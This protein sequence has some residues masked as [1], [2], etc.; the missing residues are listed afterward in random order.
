MRA[1]IGL[2][3]L[4]TIAS[5]NTHAQ[6]V[7]PSA[8]SDST[9]LALKRRNIDSLST[10]EY[11]MF[12]DRDRACVAAMGKPDSAATVQA[13]SSTEDELYFAGLAEGRTGASR[14]G[15]GG[16]FAGSF[17]TGVALG[18][19]G[20]AIMY[21]GAESSESFPN[22]AESAALDVKPP[23][24]ARGYREGYTT[25]LKSRKKNSALIGGLA[26][27]ATIVAIILSTYSP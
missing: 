8:C 2:V 23:M 12:R 3:T 5:A 25:E 16:W 20:T 21:F 9:Y 22:A 18:L 19:I 1:Q 14:H 10:R 4:L 6:G 7:S 17:A 15:T 11:E 26:G 24:F 13:G 27:T